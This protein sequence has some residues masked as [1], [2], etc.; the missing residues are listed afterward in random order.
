MQGAL[1]LSDHWSCRAASFPLPPPFP[2]PSVRYWFIITLF[3]NKSNGPMDIVYL[4]ATTVEYRCLRLQ[5][6]HQTPSIQF[7][8]CCSSRT[9]CFRTTFFSYFSSTIV[10]VARIILKSGRSLDGPIIK[11]WQ[12]SVFFFNATHPPPPISPFLRLCSHNRTIS[13]LAWHCQPRLVGLG[14][15]RTDVSS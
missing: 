14:L 12:C 11:Q 8:F 15:T 9:A 10:P 3:V 7:L 13:S 4:K 5:H 2:S 1:P 6:V